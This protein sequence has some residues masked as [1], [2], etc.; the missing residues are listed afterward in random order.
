MPINTE[1][2][3]NTPS[4]S[5]FFSEAVGKGTLFYLI[6]RP[7]EL[8]MPEIQFPQPLVEPVRQ[9]QEN[10]PPHQDPPVVQDPNAS[11]EP[12]STAGKR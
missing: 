3:Q 6:T 12:V 11:A 2:E 9:N 7:R 5:V 8:V 1:S 10:P 4:C